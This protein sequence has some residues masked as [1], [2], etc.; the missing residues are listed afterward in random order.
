MREYA[1]SLAERRRIAA[2]YRERYRT[3]AEYRLR[4]VNCLRIRQG[5][6]PR[7]SV[8]EIAPKAGRA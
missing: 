8:D 2:Y 4:K 1:T 7:A 5:L 3:D 6:P